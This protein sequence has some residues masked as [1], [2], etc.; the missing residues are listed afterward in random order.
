[1]STTPMTPELNDAPA[2]PATQDDAAQ[3]PQAAQPQAAPAQ[4]QSRLGA[5]VQAVAKVA[6]AGLQGIPDKGRPNFISGLGEGA[7]SAQALKFKSFDDQVRLAQLHN[8]DIKLQ[9]DTQ[10]QTD[11]HKRA[12]LDN[13]ALANSLG[14][15][16]DTIPSDGKAVMDHLQAQTAASG[17]ASVPPGTHLSGDGSTVNIPKDNQATRDGQKQMYG[18]LG[19]ALGLPSLPPSAQFVPPNLMNMLTNKL[20]GYSI[21]GKPINHEE[22][23][24]AIGALQAQRDALAKNGASPDQLKA[25]D[26]TLGIYKANLNALDEHAAGVKAKGKQA[27]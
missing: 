24:G 20:H 26:N 6:S 12:E 11:A 2:A 8:Q 9:N 16:Y 23:P 25:I 21:D 18:M 19:P 7:R 13:R 10:E 17:A 14:I 4:P 22:L 15:D 5:I 3:Q 1:M 27:E